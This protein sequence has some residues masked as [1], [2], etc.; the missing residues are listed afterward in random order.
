MA[1]VTAG[2]TA[3]PTSGPTA[4]PTVDS[5]SCAS[6]S[7]NIGCNSTNPD[8]CPCPSLS[9][10]ERTQILDAHNVRRE[11]A[12]SG[13]EVCATSNGSSTEPCPAATDMNAL[14]WDGELET[15]ATYWAHQF[16]AL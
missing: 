8:G 12:A 15:I 5:G 1:P 13:N 16:S 4:D 6:G 3:D 14:I 10:D 7:Y 2:P 11:L 9:D